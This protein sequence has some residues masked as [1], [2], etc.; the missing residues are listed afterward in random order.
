MRYTLLEREV[1]TLSFRTQAKLRILHV[2]PSLAASD[3]GTATAVTGMCRELIRS[4]HA[5]EIYTTNADGRCYRGVPLG[6]SITTQDVPV[7]YFPVIG[8]NYYKVSPRFA[9]ALRNKVP[10]VDLVHIHSLYQFP[11]TAAARYCRKY[12][13]PY[14]VMPHGTLDP[15]LYR[16]HAIRKRLY[17]SIIEQH[18]VAQAAAL[19]FTSTEEMR[20]AKLSGLRFRAMVAPLGVDFER[21]PENWQTIVNARW[22][23][24][25]GK[26]VV[27]FLGR[28]NFKKGLDLLVRAFSQIY[29]ER[30]G[31]HL[32]IAGPDNEGFGRKVR[33]WLSAERCLSGV[34]F[35]GMLE[36]APKLALLKRAQVFVVPSY[37]E[38]FCIA[39]VEAMAI[40]VPV[41]LSN[42]VNI[43]GEIS[44]AGAGLVVNTNPDELAGAIWKV[45]AN[46]SLAREIGRRGYEL[47]R[48]HFSW[49]TAGHHL[50]EL[51]RAA[52]S[53]VRST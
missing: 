40:R 21:A 49:D 48:D 6:V 46:P 2:I 41:V 8:N 51:Y 34:T 13:V 47:A 4:G 28:I 16:R 32:V 30:E 3:G 15:Y 18:N 23:E 22:P 24:L 10:Q 29:R 1:N 26:Q 14:L 27:L 17:E 12:K 31:V 42:K 19:H 9:V 5:A 38:N 44:E 37:T 43:C 33:G 50:L 7:T 52:V 20:L 25:A 36:G 53:H 11:S 39:L 45:F 35:T